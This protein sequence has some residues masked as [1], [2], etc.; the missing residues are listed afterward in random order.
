[1][2]FN[3]ITHLLFEAQ[4]KVNVFVFFLLEV[5]YLILSFHWIFCDKFLKK[6]TN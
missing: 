6:E 2:K 3:Q 5:K 1:M 4:L